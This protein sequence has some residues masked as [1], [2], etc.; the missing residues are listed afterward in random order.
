MAKTSTGNKKNQMAFQVFKT[1]QEKGVPEFIT[2]YEAYN[3]TGGIVGKHNKSNA[4]R[5]IDVAVKFIN[6]GGKV[7]A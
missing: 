7:N 6:N 5:L 1:W 3:L 2:S 4:M